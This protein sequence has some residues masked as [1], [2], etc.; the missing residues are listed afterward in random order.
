MT[1]AAQNYPEL[2]EEDD[3]GDVEV[4]RAGPVCVVRINRPQRLNAF[5]SRTVDQLIAA[6]RRARADKDVGA[7]VLTGAGPKAFC[8][9]GDQYLA[10]VIGEKRARQM[11]LLGDRVDAP[12]ALEWGLVNAVVEHDDV[13]S[14]ALAWA[15][16][17]ATMSPTATAVLK[18]SLN[19]DTEHIAGLGRVC[20]STLALFGHT[21]EAEEG[22]TAFVEK[23]HADFSAFRAGTTGEKK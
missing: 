14:H 9:G 10:R 12:T 19:A 18:H 4:L 3:L 23:R 20:F 22:Y 2:L 17:C 15:D 5:T 21:A 11:L 8:A 16:R 1:A 13:L 7:L 6:F